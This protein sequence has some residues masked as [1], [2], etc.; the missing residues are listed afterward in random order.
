MSYIIYSSGNLTTTG[1]YC[2]YDSTAG[3]C[4]S[5]AAYVDTASKNLKVFSSTTALNQSCG[6]VVY[7]YSGNLYQT[8]K[9]CVAMV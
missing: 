5:Q 6:Y 9:T 3:L 7:Y 1:I 4:T 2:L 8:S